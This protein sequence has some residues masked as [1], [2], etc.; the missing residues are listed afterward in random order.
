MKHKDFYVVGKEWS[1][2]LSVLN[3]QGS[4]TVWGGLEHLHTTNDNNANY[5]GD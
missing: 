3:K 1:E 4:E 5:R 2:T